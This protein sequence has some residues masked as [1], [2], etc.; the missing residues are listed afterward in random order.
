MSIELKKTVVDIGLRRELFVDDW[1]IENMHGLSLKLHSPVKREVALRFDAPWEGSTSGGD[2][3]G[4]IKDEDRYRM[5]YRG[6]EHHYG[7]YHAFI[8]YAES[9]DGIT[10]TKPSLGTFEVEGS[11]GN[12]IIWTGYGT[13]AFSAFKDG[14]PDV[15][16][17]ERYKALAGADMEGP[18]PIYLASA[19]AIHWRQIGEEPVIFPYETCDE[20]GDTSDIPSFW[21]AEQGQYVAYFRGWRTSRS[22][23]TPCQDDPDPFAGNWMEGAHWGGGFRQVLRSTSPDFINWTAPRF[24]DFGETPLEQLYT[25]GAAPYFLAPHIYLG[26]P[27]RDVLERKKLKG[28]PEQGVFDTVFMSSRDGVHW[29]RRFMEAF[30]RPDLDPKNWTAHSV[31][32]AWGVVQTGPDE[33]SMYYA[34]HYGLPTA[35]LSRATLRTDGFVSVH[36]DYGGGEFVTRPITFQG[37]RLIINYST[38]AVGSVKVEIQDANGRPVPGY[39]LGNS[40]EIY[41]DETEHEVAWTGGPFLGDLASAL[42]ARGLNRPARLKFVMKDADLYSLRF[43]A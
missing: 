32:P 40:P 18:S 20:T 27:G 26:F 8:C 4:V 1:L 17:D 2:T 23:L 21:D 30:I 38:S 10:W 43:S 35:R 9:S 24:I 33:L 28:H 39:T 5:Y 37:G 31:M 42:R 6:S 36:A 3:V 29:D 12:N 13:E 22:T 11:T 14:N 15:P 19:D 34:E 41:G 7:P 25:S 16:E